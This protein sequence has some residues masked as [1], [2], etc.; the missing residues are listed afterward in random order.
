[1]SEWIESDCPLCGIERCERLALT[2]H[3]VQRIKCVACGDVVISDYILDLNYFDSDKFWTRAKRSALVHSVRRKL[4]FPFWAQTEMPFVSEL[5]LKEIENEGLSLPS[6]LTQMD[7]LVRYLGIKEDELGRPPDP[8]EAGLWALVGAAGRVEFGNLVNDLVEVGLV[9]S[10]ANVVEDS[11]DDVTVFGARLTPEGCIRYSEVS[12]GDTR[13][14]D[15]FI[16]MPFGNERLDRFVSDVIQAGVRDRL[17]V[18]IHRADSKDKMRADLIDNIMREAIEEAAFVLVDLS[19][20][21]LGAYWEAG[22]AEGLRKP[23]IYLCEK[24]VWEDEQHPNRPHFDVNHRTTIMWEEN[25]P[26][27]FLDLLVATIKNS[28]RH[29]NN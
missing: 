9:S 14:K 18:Q 10:I 13:S 27:E 3:A 7:N 8:L 23:V 25:K 11:D 4:D 12:E 24:C 21:N 15:G 22:L 17:G 19:H 16:A 20:G 29:K 28:L 2:S 1:M 6:R 5:R 26:D